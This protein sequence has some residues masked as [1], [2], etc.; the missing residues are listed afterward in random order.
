M[1]WGSRAQSAAPPRSIL[2]IDQVAQW[3]GLSSVSPLVLLASLLIL[4]ALSPILLVVFFG[5][6]VH[7]LSESLVVP[8]RI[9]SSLSVGSALSMSAPPNATA[10]WLISTDCRIAPS[11]LTWRWNGRFALLCYAVFL[12]QPRIPRL[13]TAVN[14]S[15]G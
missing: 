4:I 7:Q 8:T 6:Y 1:H 3:L 5:E 15:A 10:T 11:M 13:S 12:F 2:P 9:V 14:Q